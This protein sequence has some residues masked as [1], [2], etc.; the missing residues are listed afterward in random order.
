MPVKLGYLVSHPIQYQAPLLRQIA[1]T[2]GID[3]HVF[4]MSDFSVRSYV[5]VEFGQKVEWDTP[6]LQGYSHEF[7]PLKQEAESS[8]KSVIRNYGVTKALAKAN[9]DVLWM[10]GYSH[11]TTIKALLWGNA[12]GVPTLVR[13]ENQRKA[14]TR[15]AKLPQLKETGVKQILRLPSAF[16]AVG[17]L[18]A[19]YYQSMGVAKEK[20]FRVP[21]A[22]DNQK[23]C[24]VPD[25]EEMNA[26][27]ASLR[28]RYGI[29]ENSPIILFASKLTARKRCDDLVKAFLQIKDHPS[30]PYLLVVGSGPDEAAP[31]ELAKV[32]PD[33]IIFCGFQ[34]QGALPQF[35]A[36]CDVFVLPS[37]R[38]QWGLV[39]NEVMCA[40]K[41]VIATDDVGSTADLIKNGENGYVYPVRSIDGLAKALTDTLDNGRYRE[42]GRRSFEIIQGW[43]FKEDI[44]GLQQAIAY[45]RKGK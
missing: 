11:A 19:E 26:H 27:R 18:N 39:V 17:T 1:E 5:D 43:S 33:R 25:S 12:K 44:E 20:I 10:H 8:S 9:L 42:M 2:E 34:N 30:K 38:E 24:V 35:Y 13:A 14:I 28:A 15:P 36:G 16:L 40:G 22:I 7:L 31:R 21:Y 45:V 37:E 3:L 29:P 41:P 23:F 6:L 4:F 32:E